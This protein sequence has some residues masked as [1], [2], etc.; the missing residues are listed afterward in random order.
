LRLPARE[1][2]TYGSSRELTGRAWFQRREIKISHGYFA[3]KESK[4]ESS[5]KTKVQQA[6]TKV[7]MVLT[8]KK[9]EI[10]GQTCDS[11]V[12]SP[13]TSEDG[14]T[15]QLEPGEQRI[16]ATGTCPSKDA[17]TFVLPKA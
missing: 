17:E 4:R 15:V 14:S 8:W 2:S 6:T 3:D 7:K 13:I 12:A 9:V 16:H 5:Y 11:N 1:E 10:P